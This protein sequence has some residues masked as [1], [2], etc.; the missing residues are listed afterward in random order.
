MSSETSEKLNFV[1]PAPPVSPSAWA[2]VFSLREMGVYYALL[3]LVLVVAVITTYLGRA[4]YLSGQN[5]SN[6]FYQTSLTA[7]MAVPMTVVLVSGNFDLSVASVAA[8]AGAVLLGNADTYGFP[9]AFAF[10]MI[11]ATL[12][13]IL[14]GAIVQFLGIN[15]FIVTL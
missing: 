12:V 9:L 11:A 15:A 4:N 14:N 6:V 5:I 1:A 10:A 8:L 7:I 2:K 13:G 3:L